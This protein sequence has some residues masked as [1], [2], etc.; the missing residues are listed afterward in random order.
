MGQILHDHIQHYRKDAESFDYFNVEN[1]TIR[2]E[3]RRRIELL[4][5]QMKLV[6]GQKLIDCGSG[7]GWVSQALLPEG[8]FVCAVDLSSRNLIE[9]RKRFD[10][11]RQGGYIIA[12][13]THLPFKKSS[14]D[15]AT[16]ND[17]YEHLEALDAASREL[18]GVLKQGAR[19][20]I[21][22]PYKE[23]IV[24]YL[25][26]HC[27]QLTPINAHL[28]SFDENSLGEIFEKGGFQ[29]E[30][31]QKFMNKGMALLQIYVLCRWMPYWLWRFIDRA[32]NLIIKKP[33]RLAMIFV[34][35]ERE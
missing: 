20:F 19:A 25:C 5:R 28:H 21:S 4:I 13:L 34:A 15:G 1:P 14:F 24:Y 22:V 11:G 29:I 35:N 6:A 18:R 17:V 9:I 23:N 31:I 27:N 32:A 26:I 16:S 2:Q 8:V 30:T 33:G 7:G 3:E 12:D 10:S